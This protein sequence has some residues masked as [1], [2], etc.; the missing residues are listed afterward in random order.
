MEAINECFII[1]AAYH[2]FLF[3]DFV[4]DPNLQYSLG[5]SLIAIT[6]IN[7][8]L[9]IGVLIGVSIRRIKLSCLL[10]KL[11]LK[12]WNESGNK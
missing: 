9:N 7:I 4:P 2:L 1:A 11:K 3:T 8:V 6:I 5:W 10:L 12:K